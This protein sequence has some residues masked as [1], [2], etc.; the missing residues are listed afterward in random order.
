MKTQLLIRLII[1]ILFFNQDLISAQKIY[2]SPTGSDDNPGTSEKPLATFTA[3]RDKARDLRKNGQVKEP[4]EII[5]LE[6]DYFMIQPLTLTVEDGGTEMSPLIFKAEAGKKSVF[7]GG[8][9]I[10]GW[11]KVNEKLWK[12]F[13]PQVAYY[14]SYFEQLYVN[15]R[16]AVRARTPNDIFYPVKSVNETVM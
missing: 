7:R 2:L 11:E 5:A 15:D 8:V 14:N 9:K 4:I 6:G 1:V 3:A 16:R 10:T 13:V 12:A